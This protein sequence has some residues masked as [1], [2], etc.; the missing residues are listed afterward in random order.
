M[1]AEAMAAEVTDQL[2]IA[3]RRADDRFSRALAVGL[4]VVGVVCLL[5]ISWLASKGG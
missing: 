3:Q 2:V 5:A 1:Q 4:F